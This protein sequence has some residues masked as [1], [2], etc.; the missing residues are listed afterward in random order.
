MWKPIKGYEGYYEVSDYG[1]V[2]SLD[3]FDVRTD[4]NT[5][6]H[7]GRTMK[8]TI[9]KGRGSEGKR[10][11]YAVVNLRTPGSSRTRQVHRLVAEA[12]IPNPSN[13]PTVNHKDGNK[14]NNVV[15]NLEWASYS[16]N[17]VHA[18]THRLRAP[19]GNAIQQIDG[20]GNVVAEY[21]SA[22]EAAR[23]TGM[24]RCCISHC[25]NGRMDSHGGYS[26]VKKSEGAT[27]NCT[28]EIDAD[29]SASH[30]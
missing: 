27:T 3:R 19:R 18:L 23:V 14:L 12:F 26:W 1:Q 15:S 5:Y 20:N 28:S 2:R 10:E 7:K 16:D 24:S 21:R 25:L 6:F 8:L 11:G 22:C 29:G 9:E 17:N 4:G 30:P 13:L